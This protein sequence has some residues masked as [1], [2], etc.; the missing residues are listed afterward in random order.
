M[1]DNIK[2]ATYNLRQVYLKA[3]FEWSIAEG[4]LNENPLEGLKK[5]KAQERIV[6]VPEDILT[7]LLKL[8]DSNTF[9]GVRDHSL[10]I[11]TLDCGIRPKEAISLTINDFDLKR[12]IVTIPSD[13]AKTRTARTLPILRQT[14]D[15]INYLIQVRHPSWCDTVPVFTVMRVQS[16]IQAHGEID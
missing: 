5:R 16:L 7:K 3:F 1:S 12:F 15:A 10:I 13:I 2:P 14:A 8:T 9:T 4:Y 11:F 6:D